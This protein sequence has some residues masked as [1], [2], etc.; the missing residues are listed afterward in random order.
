MA[1]FFKFVFTFEDVFLTVKSGGATF[2]KM[3]VLKAFFC[4]FFGLLHSPPPVLIS[5]HSHPLAN[6]FVLLQTFIFLNTVCQD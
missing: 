6:G 5:L 4:L 1:F 3:R 2:W